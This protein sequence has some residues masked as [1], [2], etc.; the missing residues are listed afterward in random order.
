[1]HSR[2]RG[3]VVITVADLLG[4]KPGDNPHLWYDPAA[5]PDLTKRLVQVLAQLDPAHATTYAHN[6]QVLLAS[7]APIHA[8]M[9][10]LKAKFAGTPVTATEPVFGLM[11]GAI[12]LVMLNQRFQIA[13]MNDTEPA[14]SDV[15]VFEDDLREKKVKILFYNSQVTDDLTANLLGIAHQSG[16]P[17]V[18]VYRDRAGGDELS[19]LDEL[20]T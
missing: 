20:W 8:R 4:R 16:V 18:G 11:A 3:R 14:P 9:A 10:A 2:R 19:S 12:G 13:V 6:G 15:A 7:L 5:V 1:M 17:V